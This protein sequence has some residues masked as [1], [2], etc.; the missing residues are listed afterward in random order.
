[1]LND[2]EQE[3]HKIKPHLLRIFRSTEQSSFIANAP[4]AEVVAAG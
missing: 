4:S 2:S 3:E 1:M